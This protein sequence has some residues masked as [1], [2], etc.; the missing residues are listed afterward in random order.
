[1]NG[2]INGHGS[3]TAA[4]HTTK[5]V[6]KFQLILVLPERIAIRCTVHGGAA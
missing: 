3:E 4:A 2:R 6:A 1:L 5:V